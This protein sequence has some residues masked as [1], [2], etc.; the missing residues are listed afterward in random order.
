M[1]SP[2]A[3]H[4]ATLTR[5]PY[6]EA[7]RRILAA[8]LAAVDPGEAVRQHLKAHP[9]SATWLLA[10]GKAALT[11]AQPVLEQGEVHQGLLVPKSIPP[12][13]QP[14]PGFVLQP[15][16][17]PVPGSN[18]LLAGEKALALLKRL[19]P[20]EPGLCL[21]SGGGSALL[22]ASLPGV[23]LADLQALTADLLACGARVDEINTLRRH[24]DPLKGGG[25]VRLAAPRRLQSLI[26][27]DVIGSPL[28]AIASG[29]TAPDP[30]TREQALEILEKYA[31][32]DR[33]S[34]AIRH[35]LHTAP[36]TLKPGDPLFENVQNA[37]IGDNRLAAEAALAQA[38]REGLHTR[39]LGDR[40]QGEA[41]QVAHRLCQELLSALEP[42]PFCL[43]AGGETTVTLRGSGRGG[44][45]TELALAAVTLL[46]E[47]PGVLLV[48]LASDGE[49]GPTDA[50]GAVVSGETLRRGLAYGLDPAA[51]LANNDSYAYFAALED[52]IRIGPTGTN[53]NDLMFLFGLP[54]EIT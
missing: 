19:A 49:D 9:S 31:L 32:M 38:R 47:Q 14:P 15:G 37:I 5:H 2:E 4:T 23:T 43:V 44:R 36:E 22:T 51:Y 41:R 26:L 42:R 7:V 35:A 39:W 46:A 20:T 12:G 13:Y 18:S 10:F 8:A 16:D 6:G 24:L 30:T 52:L 48:T 25:L 1:L 17:H 28:E 54:V 34:P 11:M 53:V 27:S 40:W 50:A 29:P 21:I 45:N 3:F 33:V